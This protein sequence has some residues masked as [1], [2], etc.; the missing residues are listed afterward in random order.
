[1]KEQSQA[2]AQA[3]ASPAHRLRF[4]FRFCCKDREIGTK[5]KQRKRYPSSSLSVHPTKRSNQPKQM[6][7]T[8][9]ET[10][11]QILCSFSFRVLRVLN[12]PLPSIII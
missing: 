5:E 8:N 9:Q 7:S 11:L 10:A 1:M 3:I 2:K 6:A 4:Q 12:F